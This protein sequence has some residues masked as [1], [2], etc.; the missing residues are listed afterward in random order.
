MT[1]TSQEYKYI[2]QRSESYRKSNAFEYGHDT[3]GTK[4]PE[5]KPVASITLPRSSRKG[6]LANIVISNLSKRIGPMVADKGEDKRGRKAERK[7]QGTNSGTYLA[8][9]ELGCARRAI[10]RQAIWWF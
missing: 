6:N 3:N 5:D 4:S 8:R 2:I 10:Y 7:Y 1:P 9:L